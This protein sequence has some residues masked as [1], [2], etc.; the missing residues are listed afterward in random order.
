MSIVFIAL[1]TQISSETV[2][3]LQEVRLLT[4]VFFKYYKKKLLFIMA[5][6]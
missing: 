4:K 6:T 5:N 3:Q 2:L 1:L